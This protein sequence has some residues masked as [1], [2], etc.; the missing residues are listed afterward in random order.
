[1]ALEV[2]VFKDIHGYESKPMFGRSWRQLASLGMCLVVVAVVALVLV[3][4]QMRSGRSLS[5]ASDIAMYVVMVS[6]IPFI[7]WGFARPKGLL[8][9][10]FFGFV[11]VE[12]LSVKEIY[13]GDTYCVSGRES[14]PGGGPRTGRKGRRA[15]RQEKARIVCLEGASP[16]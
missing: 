15:A 13:Y 14:A 11:V 7:A 12:V 3:W 5:Q 6:V 4:P 10:Q 16:E 2:K 1:M 9:E 8:P